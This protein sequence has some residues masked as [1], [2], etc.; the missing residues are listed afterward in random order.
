MKSAFFRVLFLVP[1]SNGDCVQSFAL[2][3]KLPLTRVVYLVIHGNRSVQQA[4]TR[5]AFKKINKRTL[6]AIN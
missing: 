3:S 2:L 4:L 5:M 6:I 1:G